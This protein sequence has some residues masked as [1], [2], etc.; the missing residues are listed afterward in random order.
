[1]SYNYK[2]SYVATFFVG[3]VALMATIS[4][5]YF[6]NQYNKISLVFNTQLALVG[7]GGSSW[8]VSPTGS[9]SGDGSINNPWDLITALEDNTVSTNKNYVV[10]PGDTIWLRSGTYT[11]PFTSKIKGTASAPIVVRNYNNE[12]VVIND[13]FQAT[14]AEP[15]TPISGWTTRYEMR[16]T[17]GEKWPLGYTA[18]INGIGLYL[19]NPSSVYSKNPADANK[20]NVEVAS[21]PADFVNIPVGTAIIKGGCII[22]HSGSYTW[23]W[24]LEITSVREE[25]FTDQFNKGCGLN[26]QA[27]GVGNKSINNIIYNVGHPAIGFWKQSDQGEIYGNLLWGNGIYDNSN[28]SQPNGWTRGGGI[29]SQ[30]EVGNILISDVISFKNFTGGMKCHGES[31]FCNGVTFEGNIVFDNPDRGIAITT[32]VQPANLNT[33]NYNNAYRNGIGFGY[34]AKNNGEAVAI[35]NYVAEA[36]PS[37]VDGGVFGIKEYQKVTVKNNTFYNFGANRVVLSFIMPTGFS[38]SNA[39]W[40]YNKYYGADQ[41]DENDPR[42][43]TKAGWEISPYSAPGWKYLSDLPTWEKNSTLSLTDIPENKIIIRPNKYEKGRANI[44]VWNWQKN[45]SVTLDL[46][47]SGLVDGDK[48][49]IRDAQNY[50][51]TPVVNGTYRSFDPN[52]VL[53]LNLQVVSP[54]IGNVN[55]LNKDH[56]PIEFNVFVVLKV[57]EDNMSPHNTPDTIA[58]VISNLRLKKLFNKSIEISWVTNEDATTQVEYGTSLPGMMIPTISTT[59]TSNHSV[60]IPD[61][62]RGMSY[63]IKVYS[64]D[65]AGNLTTLEVPVFIVP[66]KPA[67]VLFI[68]AQSG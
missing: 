11:G 32:A 28:P 6:L 29:Y 51:G 5:V 41:F 35:G 45:N 65:Q 43:L 50:F 10:K 44:V 9:S 36:M 46:S 18:R 26:L 31:G 24:G 62:T 54:I 30:N 27:V 59:Y 3:L 20:Y 12:K 8:Y 34:V 58:P 39:D 56:T 61:L 48:F 47:T 55:H 60:I 64:R 19:L 38:Y 4:T 16:I 25:R 57:G 33:I 68:S 67:P 49:E 22:D 13:N 53:P 2:F 17:N 23:F 42:V 14:L 37:G 21:A 1:M 66:L 15:I 7:T 63:Y 52:V 40:N